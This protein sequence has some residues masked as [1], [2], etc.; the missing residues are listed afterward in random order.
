[1][2]SVE[3]EKAKWVVKENLCPA[4]LQRVVTD[5]KETIEDRTQYFTAM[6]MSSTSVRRFLACLA[7][8][9]FKML[10]LMKGSFPTIL[11]T[12]QTLHASDE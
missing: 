3:V 1:M 9:I 8:A 4:F 7:A 5:G 2:T 6:L 12:E 10:Y 11:V